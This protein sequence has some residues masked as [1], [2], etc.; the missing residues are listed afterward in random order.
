[1]RTSLFPVLCCGLDSNHFERKK[2]YSSFREF[3]D[4]AIKPGLVSQTWNSRLESLPSPSFQL[5]HVRVVSM[6]FG[7]FAGSKA[8]KSKDKKMTKNRDQ[9]CEFKSNLDGRSKGVWLFKK[10]EVNIF[11]L[12]NIEMMIYWIDS[13]QPG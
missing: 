2:K 7:Q 11:F 9:T 5:N 13:G 10:I 8:K 12:L 6:W 3:F 4:I 1:L